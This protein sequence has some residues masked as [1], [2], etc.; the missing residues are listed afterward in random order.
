M[1]LIECQNVSKCFRR[2]VG[3]KLL[4]D[5]IGD[6]VQNDREDDDERFFAL[7]DVSFRIE[8]GHSLG[9]IGRNGAGKSTLLSLISGLAPPD[10]GTV[11]VSGRLAALLE[12]GSGFHPDLTGIENLRLNAALM[13]F[14][15]AQADELQQ[16]IID[17]SE[18]KDFI[19]EPLRSY[20]AGMV[21]RLGF[22][23]AMNLRPDIL[24]VDEVLAVGDAGFQQKCLERIRELQRAGTALLFVTHAVT[25]IAMFCD[26]T[27]WLHEGRVMAL[28]D[29]TE[30]AQQYL[31]FTYGQPESPAVEERRRVKKRALP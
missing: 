19:Y 14:T 27:L 25:N 23:V 1:A 5:H 8:S 30:V 26:T 6:I 20:S 22:A 18:L 10:R 3:S 29:S 17:F 12:L 13:G 16:S 9:V 2:T 11:N 31:N 28:G 21:L 7:R 4:R 15:R 24:I